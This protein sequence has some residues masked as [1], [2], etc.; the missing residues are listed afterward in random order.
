VKSGLEKLL[1]E[2]DAD[3]LMLNSMIFDHAARLRAYEIVAEVWKEDASA[4]TA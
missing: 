2:T 3:E 1:A 4:H